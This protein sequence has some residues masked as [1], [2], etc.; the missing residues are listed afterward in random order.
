MDICKICGG[1]TFYFELCSFCNSEHDY[2]NIGDRIELIYKQYEYYYNREWDAE[3][4][5]ESI[6][7]H[8]AERLLYIRMHNEDV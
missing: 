7:K 6:R 4:N 5:V 2:L 3:S 1:R 8:F